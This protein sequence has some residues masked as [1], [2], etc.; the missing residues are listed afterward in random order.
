[1]GTISVSGGGGG[2][3]AVILRVNGLS[4]TS[5][6]ATLG[7]KTVSGTI[8]AAGV[9]EMS[10]GKVG[11]WTVKATSGSYSFTQ[12]VKAFAYGITE[13]W[14]LAKKAFYDCTTTEIQAIAQSG[15]ASQYWAIGDYH[16]ITMKDDEEIEV[17]IADFNHDV[18]PG[19]ETIPVTLLMK[20][21]FK[22]IRT[23]GTSATNTGGWTN[24]NFRTST[25]PSILSNFPDEW[26]NIMTTAQKK[27]SQGVSNATIVTSDDKVWL[28]SQIE[29]SG[30]NG[31]SYAGEGTQ[32]PIFTDNASRI[33]RVNNS[34]NNYWS[35][36]PA[37]GSSQ[38]FCYVDSLG[39]PALSSAAQNSMGISLGFCVG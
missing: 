27:T 35:R 29:L 6:S 4:G 28:L 33:K 7:S 38:S 15:M 32:Y 22:T 24:S 25:L 36:S 12:Q 30:S 31:Q 26:Q 23:V 5:I 34:A 1:M 16:K 39:N 2:G 11:Q 8:P 20:N 21:C 10:L 14:A 13:I 37:S 19:G 3:G 17:A 9:L 18:T